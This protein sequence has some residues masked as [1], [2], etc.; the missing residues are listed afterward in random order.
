MQ[1]FGWSDN[2]VGETGAKAMA[3]ALQRDNT[4]T[5]RKI[6][7]EWSCLLFWKNWICVWYGMLNAMYWQ[8]ILIHVKCNI[9]VDQLTKSVMLVQKRWQ[10]HCNAITR[11]R[12]WILHVSVVIPYGSGNSPYMDSYLYV[13]KFTMMPISLFSLSNMSMIMHDTVCNM[14][15][16]IYKQHFCAIN[17]WVVF[18]ITSTELM[19]L[20]LIFRQLATVSTSIEVKYTIPL[21]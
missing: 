1:Y 11:W 10:M 8:N 18:A 2:Q 13:F 3:D 4:L 6:S 12:L 5:T 16:H 15:Y 19:R 9:L 20:E 14:V 21:I 17:L 7:G